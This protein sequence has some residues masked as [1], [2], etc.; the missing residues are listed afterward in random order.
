[1]SSSKFDPCRS[2]PDASCRRGLPTSLQPEPEGSLAMDSSA[3]DQRADSSNTRSERSSQ[4]RGDDC[5]TGKEL[6]EKILLLLKWI[7]EE[8]G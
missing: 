7:Q 8:H 2:R 1:M 4:R 6:E 5:G 3:K